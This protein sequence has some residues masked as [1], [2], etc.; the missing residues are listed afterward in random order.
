[1]KAWRPVG[2]ALWPAKK[3]RAESPTRACRDESRHG[4][5]KSAPLGTALLL[6]VCA[7]GQQQQAIPH[8]GYVYPAGGRQDTTFQ[9]TVGG[10]FL[11]GASD[12]LV[13]GTG[14]KATVL[15]YVRPLTP[16]Q[17]NDLREQMQK[18]NQKSNGGAALTPAEVRTLADI[19]EKLADFVRRPASP[20]IQETVLLEVMV[21]RD[22][23][24][25]VRELRISAGSGLTNPMALCVGQ[26]PEFS[27]P[28]AKV[29]PAFNVVNGA[30]PPP[31]LVTAGSREAPMKVTLPAILNG[32]MMPAATDRYQF[33]ASKGQRIVI[34]TA[35][36]ELIPYISDAVP[37]WF[38]AAISLRDAAGREI[39]SADHYQFHPDP[40]LYYEIPASGDYILE[41]HDSIYRGREDFVYRITAGELPL[42][43]GIFPLGGKSGAKTKVEFRGWNLPSA[44]QV[45]DERGK[46]RGVQPVSLKGSNALPFTVDTLPETAA[47]DGANRREKAQKL[48]LPVVVNGRIGHAGDQQFFRIDARAGE[49]ITAE[50]FAR[51]LDSPLDSVLRLTDGAGKELAFNDDFEDKGA[52][53]LTHQA[54]SRICFRFP[55]KGTYY[56]QL[57]DTQRKGGPEYAY[58]LR[59]AHPEPDFDLRVAPSSLNLRAGATVPVT[60]YAL[61]RDGFTGE[62]ALKLKDAPAGFT[63]SGAAIPAGEDKVRVTVTAPRSGAG[64]PAP[65]HLEGHAAVA[66]RE[67][68]HLAVPAEEMMQ[69]FAYR[70]LVPESE[71]MARVIGQGQPANLRPASERTIQVPAGGTASVQMAVP[72]RLAGDVKFAL[73]EPPDGMAVES[74]TPSGN[75]VTVVVR[76]T[77]DKT[78]PGLKGNLIFDAFVERPAPNQGANAKRKQAMGTVPAIP[79]E[80]VAPR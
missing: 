16:A 53:L 43:T 56:L 75:G 27:R 8:I 14:V 55:D 20:A 4:R 9:V 36:R 31:R 62:I 50:V 45:M 44:T 41:I 63:M 54:D 34:A 15:K 52:G 69:A 40:V 12:A 17:A 42:L 19:R 35:A 77:G 79:F 21:A 1:M 10:Q 6:A 65:I 71:W 28:P 58:R 29:P 37:G 59:I 80:V 32:Q 72:A 57:A 2:Q 64:T 3:Y 46:P 51:R 47:K 39:E 48:K 24:P 13:S 11:Q 67:V 70:H 7:F 78:K 33:A 5:L 61:R 22:A 26:L 49:D 23:A 73:N 30:T 76:A 60:V 18:L 74:V 66:G 68:K 38:Q 25:G